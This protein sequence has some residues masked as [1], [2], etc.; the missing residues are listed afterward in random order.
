VEVRRRRIAEIEDSVHLVKGLID[1]PGVVA[2][3][4]VEDDEGR[5]SNRSQ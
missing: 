2:H 4:F 5:G 1:F 3:F